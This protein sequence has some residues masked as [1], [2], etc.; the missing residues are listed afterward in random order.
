VQNVTSPVAPPVGE[1]PEKNYS[2]DY[3]LVHF[4]I[5]DSTA[6]GG[7]GN[8]SARQAAIANWLAADLAASN[9]PWK[10]AACHHPPKSYFSH[11]DTGDGM[12]CEVMPILI[13]GGADLLL[14]GHSH[15]YQRSF[16][17]T[18]HSGAPGCTTGDV[19][20]IADQSGAY[21]K[22]AQTIEV[23]AGTG[24]ENID[25]PA[26]TTATQWIAKAFG[27][28]NGGVIGPFI[29]DVTAEQ[30]V[31]KYTSASDG[32]I[33]DQFTISVPGPTISL[34]PT[35]LTRTQFIGD[36]LAADTF[37]VRNS[38]IDTITYSIS[39]DADWLSVSPDSG[40]STGEADTITITYDT[41]AL[42]AGVYNAVITVSAPEDAGGPKAL[43]VSLTVESV[44]PDID[45][46]G[47][48]D[49]TDFAF[50]Q[51]CFAGSGTAVTG[52]CTRADFTLDDRVD[53]ADLSVYLACQTQADV[54][55]NRNCD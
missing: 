13:A 30:L 26:P 31:C 18:G 3:G 38:G 5:F 32:S 41:A 39:D 55:A 36:T 37:T 19:T 43:A 46:D 21:F 51:I 1:T 12:A 47:D 2:F 17:I 16:P 28:N 48:V 49:Q 9:Q 11:S 15:D 22:G 33:K 4:V 53:A 6:W 45:G 23:V 10:I 27:N 54:A 40:S 34:S 44:K 42:P 20:W 29:I 14:V 50:L 24:G 25:G 7:P 35:S 52:P 8:T